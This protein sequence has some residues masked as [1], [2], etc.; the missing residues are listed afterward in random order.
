VSSGSS[1][2]RRREPKSWLKFEDVV[3]CRDV[4]SFHAFTR[5][6][7]SERELV[8]ESQRRTYWALFYAWK[9]RTS[10]HTLDDKK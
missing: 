7:L 4:E 9:N 10:P 8:G 3:N 5:Q 1:K 6:F 2:R